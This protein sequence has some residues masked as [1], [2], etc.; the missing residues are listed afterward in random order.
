MKELI[1]Q[2]ESETGIAKGSGETIREY[3]DKVADRC[4]ID[5]E[6]SNDLINEITAM[7]FSPESPEVDPELVERF[8]DSAE[9][10]QDT[11]QDGSRGEEVSS[12]SVVKESKTKQDDGS[13]ESCEFSEDRS[14]SGKQNTETIQSNSVN[15]R[16]DF[17]IS[18]QYI[19]QKIH[20][21][22]G[23]E[24]QINQ[25]I[26][27]GVDKLWQISNE[28]CVFLVV[29]ALAAYL[30]FFNL[31]SYPLSTWDE[32]IYGNVAQNMVLDGNWLSPTVQWGGYNDRYF[33]EK[34]PGAFWLQALA[35]LVLGVSEFAVRF[36]SALAALGVTILTY[37]FGMEIFH[38]R[39]GL[40]AAVIWVFTPFVLFG[41]NAARTGGTDTLT[42]FFGTAFIFTTWRLTFSDSTNSKYI[43]VGITAAAV[44]LVKGFAAGIFVL[45][46]IPLVIYRWEKYVQLSF[47]KTIATTAVIAMPWP[48]YA[49]LR[50]QSEFV[51]QILIQQVLGRV[52]GGSF[53]Q[54]EGVF[55]F[56]K[57]P[58]FQGL[59]TFFDPWV[60]WLFPGMIY[61]TANVYNSF[62][63]INIRALFPAW[64]FIVIVLFYALTGNHGWYILPSYVPGALIVGKLL[65]DSTSGND[66]AKIMTLLG[67]FLTLIFST[68][69]SSLSPLAIPKPMFNGRVLDILVPY[70][71]GA[72]F[73]IAISVLTGLLVGYDQVN[74][75][76]QL[77]S[78]SDRELAHTVLICGVLL[79]LLVSMVGISPPIVNQSEK[80]IQEKELGIEIRQTTTPGTAVY[81]QKTVL[82]ETGPKTTMTFYAQRDIIITDLSQINSDSTI[83]YAII[84]GNS[85]GQIE[86]N[87]QIITEK[88]GGKVV[89]IHFTD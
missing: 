30:F 16:F 2:I 44:L 60:F 54:F 10:V 24:K 21:Y 73:G 76:I 40:F 75:K 19:S 65:S 82:S 31:G 48:L 45:A 64:W 8:L 66:L 6:I 80:D 18:S 7:M 25:K 20:K 71:E 14:P 67:G 72:F 61:I 49:Y 78:R 23:S 51:D 5:E 86:R 89:Y 57:F 43:L 62:D 84:S 56:M 68:R 38:K 77:L 53:V 17:D 32:A 50:H 55:W 74:K 11:S 39:A 46:V 1:N 13:E 52:S 42:T 9:Y 47:I 26:S 88:E 79:I 81:L 41:A 70:P 4:R 22:S 83:E 36:P 85:R 28:H 29:L 58:Y 35:M 27:G 37:W 34:P 69:L 63:K 12:P 59:F 15:K 87:H 3:I 33:L